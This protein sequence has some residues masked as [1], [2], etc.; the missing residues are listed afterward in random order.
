MP[1]FAGL[2]SGDRIIAMNG[3]LVASLSNDERI[4][5]L[6]GSPLLLKVSRAGGVVELTMSLD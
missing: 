5:L 3:K 6:R 4:S 1:C 2:K